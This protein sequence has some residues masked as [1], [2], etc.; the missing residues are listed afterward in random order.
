MKTPVSVYAKVAATMLGGIAT[1][2]AAALPNTTVGKWAAAVVAILFAMGL[3]S[4]TKNTQVVKTG[5]DPGP[6]TV[7]KLVTKTG[8]DLGALTAD[9]GAAAG[10]IVEGTTG[11]LGAA[12]NATIGKL[13]PGGK[14][15]G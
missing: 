12:M 5:D 10:G 2:L 3:V 11:V 9:T 13:L 8:E 7:A 6:V 15:R 1:A 4:R 14:R